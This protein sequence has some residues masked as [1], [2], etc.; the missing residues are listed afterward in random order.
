MPAG[1]DLNP[2]DVFVNAALKKRLQG[3][4]L[5]TAPELKKETAVALAKM[6]KSP[7]FRRQLV[8]ACK[9][10]RARV[11]W[12]AANGGRKAIRAKVKQ[13]QKEKRERELASAAVV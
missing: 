2:L 11:E 12:V 9:G 1:A 7:K 6:S 3:K 8:R 13:S 10:F 4:D 5:S